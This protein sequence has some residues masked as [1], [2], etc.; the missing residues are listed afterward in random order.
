MTAG[1]IVV[2]AG[3]GCSSLGW[4]FWLRFFWVDAIGVGRCGRSSVRF[5][6]GNWLAYVARRSM[7]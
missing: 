5:C 7:L 4:P 1:G 3:P 2:G 6:S